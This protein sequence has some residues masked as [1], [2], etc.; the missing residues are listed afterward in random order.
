MGYGMRISRVFWE[1]AEEWLGSYCNFRKLS[2]M[3]FIQVHFAR[4][5]IPVVSAVNHQSHPQFNT[6]V[7]AC[8][9]GPI[10]GAI[11]N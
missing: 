11:F 3:I 7:G 2:Q 1:V 10:D 8:A 6:T 9:P 5:S 4:N